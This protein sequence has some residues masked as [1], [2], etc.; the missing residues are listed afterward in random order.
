MHDQAVTNPT[1]IVEVLS[2]STEEYDRVDKFEHYKSIRSLQQYALVSYPTAH[3]TSPS[4][5]S[6]IL[7]LSSLYLFPRAFFHW[8]GGKL[9]VLLC[10]LIG[11]L[12]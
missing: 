5:K 11:S 12:L 9:V 7:I 8:V 2:R 3:P 4:M 1:F 6:A 10:R